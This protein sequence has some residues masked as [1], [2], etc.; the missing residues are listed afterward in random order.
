M[1]YTIRAFSRR[2]MRT[3]IAS[4]QLFSMQFERLFSIFQDFFTLVVHC[5]LSCKFLVCGATSQ[6]VLSLNTPACVVIVGWGDLIMEKDSIGYEIWWQMTDLCIRRPFHAWSFWVNYE[7]E[8]LSIACLDTLKIWTSLNGGTHNRTIIIL[9]ANKQF[10][11]V[12]NLTVGTFEVIIGNSMHRLAA[13]IAHS[14]LNICCNH[15]MQI[16]DNK[17]KMCQSMAPNSPVPHY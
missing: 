11:I 14:S 15:S 5:H 17:W 8:H 9:L 2:I 3:T 16:S 6:R 10:I 1:L 7:S 13:F 12:W 4:Y